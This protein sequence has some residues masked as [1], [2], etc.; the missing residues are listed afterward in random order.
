MRGQAGLDLLREAVAL[1]E[2]SAARL[3]L[4]RAL[5]ELG[6][7]MRRAGQRAETRASLAR[8]HELARACG[9]D[10]LAQRAATELQATGAR[11]RLQLATGLDAL[12]ASELRV[13]KMAAE[14]LSNP[15]IAQALFVSTKTVETH[16]GHAYKKLGIGSRR[17]LA[18]LLRD[19]RDV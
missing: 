16:L 3:E 7:A 14:G 1:L 11:P 13:V 2:P 6:A 12:T 15:Q 18:S 9:A 8:G 17:Q 19:E 10:A 4:A 5:L